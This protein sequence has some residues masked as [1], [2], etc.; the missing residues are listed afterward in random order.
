MMTWPRNASPGRYPDAT[1][2][3]SASPNNRCR[4]AE[5]WLSRS[6]T[7]CAQSFRSR[8]MLGPPGMHGESCRPAASF[9]NLRM[10]TFLFNRTAMSPH[11]RQCAPIL[12][13]K[14]KWSRGESRQILGCFIAAVSRL[15]AGEA[16]PTRGFR[17]ADDFNLVRGLPRHFQFAGWNRSL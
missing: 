6:P 10:N 3:Q 15:S 5:P 4:T 12:A 1:A 7:I 16:C 2:L 17:S 11:Q 9:A 8:V 13:I 14:S